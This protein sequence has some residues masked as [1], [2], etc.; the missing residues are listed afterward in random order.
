MS[1]R[2]KSHRGEVTVVFCDLR[3]FTAFAERAEPEEVMTVL[4]EYHNTLGLVID[5]YEGTVER[6]AGDGVMVLFNDPLPCPDPSARACE[7]GS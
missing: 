6:F 4:R 2:F 1:G 7:N 5:K 3:N